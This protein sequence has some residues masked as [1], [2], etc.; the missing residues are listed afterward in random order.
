LPTSAGRIACA[1][2]NSTAAVRSAE[3]VMI[4]TWL[5]PSCLIADVTCRSR[6]TTLASKK[7]EP[8]VPRYLG[9]EGMLLFAGTSL[10]FWMLKPLG[11]IITTIC[12]VFVGE[13]V[14]VKLVKS[15]PLKKPVVPVSGAGLREPPIT[16]TRACVL[17]GQSVV[18]PCHGTSDRREHSAE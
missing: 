6:L 3:L 14:S 5:A 8:P 7:P 9:S 10:T 16:L 11:S 13:M 12:Q 18:E 17:K 4:E 1:L 2:A 15:T